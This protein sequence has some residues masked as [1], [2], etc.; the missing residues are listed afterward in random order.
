M[1]TSKRA[2]CVGINNFKNYPQAALQGCVRDA[3]D[4]A[5]LLEGLPRLRSR[6]HNHPH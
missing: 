2:L 6:G 1:P 4:M 5:S 3:N